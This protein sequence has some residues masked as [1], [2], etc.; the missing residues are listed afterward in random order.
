M[1]SAEDWNDTALWALLF[2]F[3]IIA[4]FTASLC[5][6]TK[7]P[8]KWSCRY[9]FQGVRFSFHHPVG[10]SLDLYQHKLEENQDSGV[11]KILTMRRMLPCLHW[12][13]LKQGNWV[14]P[15]K[16]PRAAYC[17]LSSSVCTCR[18]SCGTN[19]SMQSPP[20]LSFFSRESTLLAWSLWSLGSIQTRTPVGLDLLD[21][22][23]F[24][25]C[26]LFL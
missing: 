2:S 19:H 20:L 24:C 23:F 7:E 5:Q 11:L 9:Q 14:H 21:A 4:H 8:K 22:D 12:L 6:S 17:A 16:I 3:H 1:M 13:C 25:F 26:F 18:L 10:F 15:A